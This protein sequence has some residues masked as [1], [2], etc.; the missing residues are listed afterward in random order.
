MKFN[1][2]NAGGESA[3]VKH[4]KDHKEK[5]G[6]TAVFLFGLVASV[7]V[8]LVMINVEKTSLSGFNVRQVYVASSDIPEGTIVTTDN[9]TSYLTVKNLDASAY[10]SNY[11]ANAADIVNYSAKYTIDAGT[12]LTS[13]MF[14]DVKSDVAAMANPREIVIN[15]DSLNRIIAG[16]LRSGDTVDLYLVTE[17]PTA[18]YNAISSIITSTNKSISADLNKESA[19]DTNTEVTSGEDEVTDSDAYEANTVVAGEDVPANHPDNMVTAEDGSDMDE[20]IVNEVIN[21]TYKNIL[22]RTCYDANGNVIANGDT[23]SIC[24]MFS[25]ILEEEDV[26]Y[27]YN[28][29]YNKCTVFVSRVIDVTAPVDVDMIQATDSDVVTEAENAVED[30]ATTASDIVSGFTGEQ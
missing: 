7:I 24:T 8:Y 11:L 29:V 16:S 25:V 2:K 15:V 21:P 10:P 14:E 27:I 3:S 19:E 6:L 17:D 30:L 28:A 22:V 5:N 26:S 12:V 9:I 13:S 18:S 4:K 1:K 23:T 20:N